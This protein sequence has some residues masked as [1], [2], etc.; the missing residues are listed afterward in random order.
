MSLFSIFPGMYN[1][2]CCEPKSACLKVNNRVWALRNNREKIN[3]DQFRD[4]SE[5]IPWNKNVQKC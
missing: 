5:N 1:A 4:Q 3:P 2:T